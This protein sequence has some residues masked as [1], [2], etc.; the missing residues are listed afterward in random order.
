MQQ[1]A[2][3]TGFLML[4]SGVLTRAF[5]RAVIRLMKLREEST[6]LSPGALRLL[7]GWELL[8]GSLL[9]WLTTRPGA[10]V[11]RVGEVIAPERRKAA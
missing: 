6:R 5:P 4:V 11:A 1:F 10:E 7:G 2:R 3:F 9:A 8:T